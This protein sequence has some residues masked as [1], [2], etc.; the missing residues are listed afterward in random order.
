MRPARRSEVIRDRGA[1][2]RGVCIEV[3]QDVRRHTFLLA[4]EAEEDVLGADV[5]VLEGA[6]LA[7]A[8]TT[9]FRARSVKCSNTERRAYRSAT[10]P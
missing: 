6:R 10:R 1:D 9:T 4:G 7:W 5:A 3:M 8:W 2:L